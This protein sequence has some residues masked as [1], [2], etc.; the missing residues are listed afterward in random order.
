MEYMYIV[1]AVVV[2]IVLVGVIIYTTSD[3][4]ASTPKQQVTTQSD[5]KTW[6]QK[7]NDSASKTNTNQ[8]G[9]MVLQ[10]TQRGKLNVVEGP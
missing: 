1:I 8:T 9:T 4:G 2:L 6:D 5:T 3:S 7:V 10:S